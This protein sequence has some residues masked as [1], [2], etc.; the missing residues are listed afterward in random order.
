VLKV[1]KLDEGG[2]HVEVFSNHYDKPP[3][4]VSESTLYIAGLKAKT[5]ESMGMGHVPLSRK[6]FDSWKPIFF[7]QSSV[8]DEELDGYRY[9]LEDKGGYF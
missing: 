3:S 5:G 8:K 6:T 2:V 4:I 1:L 9:W 7:Q